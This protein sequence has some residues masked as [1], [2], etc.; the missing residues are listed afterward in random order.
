MLCARFIPLVRLGLLALYGAII[1]CGCPK[2][3][4]AQQQPPLTIPAG[5]P[6]S[7]PAGPG[8]IP[9]DSW[10]LY[11]ELKTFTDYSNNYF[12]SPLAKIS[13]WSFGAS[14]A[15][16]AE[17][18][19]GIHTT[20]LYGDFTHVE[21][22]TNNEAITNDGEAT[23]TQQYAPLRDLTFTFLGD[24]SHHTLASALTSA[25][26]SPVA[27]TAASIL[28][29]GNTVLPNGTIVTP[30]GQIVGQIAPSTNIAGLSVVNPYDAYTATGQVQKLF[31]DGIVVLS[32]SLLRQDYEEQASQTG[33]FTAKT[34]REDASFWVGPLFYVYSDGA[35]TMN[36]NTSPIP[37]TDVYRV[38]GGL[39]TRQFGLFRASGYFGH[40][41]SRSIGSDPAG[42]NVYGGAL[43]YYPTPI[44]TV[45][46]NIDV[47]INLAPSGAAPS[48]QALNIPLT[49]PL[50]IPLSSS[51]QIISTSLNS[52]YQITPQWT[53]TALFGYTNNKTIASPI[54]EDSWVGVATLSYAIRRDLTLTWQY[55]Y[56]SIISNQAL[57]SA[58]RNFVSMSADYKF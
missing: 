2:L 21:Y 22:P 26:P 25:I 56:S 35:F 1:F 4:Y 57:T 47:T 23:I 38:V 50:Q 52:Q 33:D 12:L 3:A 37:N 28:P 27:S 32:A 53:A 13:G 43:T 10:V 6:G 15:L 20:T 17:W 41:G 18:S 51:S 44:W 5:G 42:G 29:N 14:P 54:W 8:A 45:N 11:P 55:Q 9:F 34:L 48:T 58:T 16:T 39:G 49:T 7:A 30:S 31:G 40:Q 46:A 19:N 24:Y 36:N